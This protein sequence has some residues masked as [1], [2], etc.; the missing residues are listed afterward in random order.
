MAQE[1]WR[2][3]LADEGTY[4]RRL[5]EWESDNAV[6]VHHVNAIFYWGQDTRVV[7]AKIDRLINNKGGHAYCT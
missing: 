3:D 1:N 4:W 6:C 5:G 7:A 2:S